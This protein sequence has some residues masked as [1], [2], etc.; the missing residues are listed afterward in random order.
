MRANRLSLIRLSFLTAVAVCL[1]MMLLKVLSYRPLLAMTGA[2]AL[3][4]ETGGLL[5]LYALVA[6]WATRRKNALYGAAIQSA[7]PLGLIGAT[8]EVL[9]FAQETWLDLGAGWN[10]VST[11]GLLFL[12]FLCWGVAGYQA[13]RRTGAVR[14]GVVAGS[15]SAMVTM[16]IVVLAGFAVEFYLA[17]PRP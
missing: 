11:F 3:S 15:W 13:I 14:S 8:I 2:L 12:T 7:T 4:L 6:V 9:H 17:M 10:N 5:V 16:L 1:T